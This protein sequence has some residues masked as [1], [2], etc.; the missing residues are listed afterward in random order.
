MRVRSSTA[1]LLLIV[2]PY[3]AQGVFLLHHQPLLVIRRCSECGKT[4]ALA[5]FAMQ[6]AA[7]GH[8][9][10]YVPYCNLT[11]CMCD[12]VS[13]EK[14]KA[15][16]PYTVHDSR[17]PTTQYVLSICDGMREENIEGCREHGRGHLSS[18]LILNEDGICT[19]LA[20]QGDMRG[21]VVQRNHSHTEL[22]VRYGNS[23]GHSDHRVNIVFTKGTATAPQS[24]VSK[25]D[26]PWGDG[27]EYNITWAGLEAEPALRPPPSP[28]PQ[29]TYY[30][31][32]SR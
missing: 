5:L 15:G 30:K 21:K 25:R 23:A 14:L 16:N 8:A 2:Q 19:E 20:T 10:Q 12:G 18:A 13:L 26:N 31:C 24:V 29:E 28:P 32:D 22:L 9:N 3:G 27:G 1:V 17:T 7:I 4:M 11:S 6:V